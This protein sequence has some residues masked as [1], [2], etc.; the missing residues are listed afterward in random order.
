MRPLSDKRRH[1]VCPPAMLAGFGRFEDFVG[2]GVT[3][4]GPG[5]IG[6][7]VA[8]QTVNTRKSDLLK[9]TIR[10][11]TFLPSGIKGK[12]TVGGSASHRF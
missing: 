9:L 5:T 8:A 1:G 11:T 3:N 7:N 6:G 12:Y 2:F 10:V 4:K